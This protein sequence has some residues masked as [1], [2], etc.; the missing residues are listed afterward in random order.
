MDTY[1]IDAE[2]KVKIREA[3]L[4]A[5]YK[6]TGAR[7]VPAAVSG[8]HIHLS[9]A[10][11]DALFGA[12][13]ELIPLKPLSQPGQYASKETVSLVGPKGRIDGIRVLG[14]AR[15][16]TQAEI[17]VTDSFKLGIKPAVRMSGEVTGCPGAV[18]ETKT[19]RVELGCG[20]MIAARHI[21]L[22]TEQAN[23]FGLADKQQ[24]SLKASGARGVVFNNVVVRTSDAFDMEAHI[25]TDEA[26]AA[27]IKNGDI[28]EIIL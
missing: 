21:H 7:Y 26:N 8:R 4:I 12:G 5:V 18:I 3:A 13:Y 11:I 19:G 23:A 25:D 17:S 6:Q 1:A 28:L 27:L 22:S 24:V 14:P 16:D 2:L 15:P 10:H 9:R 20:V